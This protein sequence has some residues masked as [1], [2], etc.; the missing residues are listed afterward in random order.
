MEVETFRGA[1]MIVRSEAASEVGPMDEIAIVGGEETEW[2][3]RFYDAGWSIV[4][5][6][7]A[8]VIHHGGA[9]VGTGARFRAEYAKGMFNFFWKH[10]SRLAFRCLAIGVLPTLALRS[11][12]YLTIGRWQSAGWE[13]EAARVAGRWA[14][15]G[16][17][18]R[19]ATHSSSSP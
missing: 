14:V 18:R 4:F 12:A 7:D 17:S 16:L 9:T 3:R 19:G 13:R 10:R 15:R 1:V 5:L 2:H 8:E 11:L 6:H